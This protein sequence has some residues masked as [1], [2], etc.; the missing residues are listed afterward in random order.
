MARPGAS[1]DGLIG[2]LISRPLRSLAGGHAPRLFGPTQTPFRAG[3][4]G[5]QSA[6][7]LALRNSAAAAAQARR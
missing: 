1:L 6:S 3:I 7:R 5:W 2:F 4:Q